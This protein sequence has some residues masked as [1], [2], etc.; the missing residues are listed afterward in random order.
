MK[1]FAARQDA[2][3]LTAPR[4]GALLFAGAIALFAIAIAPLI[5][6]DQPRAG[7]VDF[8]HLWSAG[9]MWASLR[10][11]YEDGRAAIFLQY[12]LPY[13]FDAPAP[14]FYPPHS[15]V[16]FGPLGFLSPG[17]AS[18]AFSLLSVAALLTSSVLFAD[19]MRMS[20]V[21]GSRLSLASAHAILL[22][23]GWNAGPVIFFHNIST[24]IIYLAIILV[25]RGVQIQSKGFVAAGLFFALI[26]PQMS[27]GIVISTL[28]LR[29]TRHA[30]A[31]AL[32]AVAIFS[33][34]GLAPGGVISSFGKFLSN[35]SAYS[36]YAANSPL[37][38]SGAAFLVAVATGVSLG[39]GIMVA[40]C[41]GVLFYLSLYSG[42]NG[43]SD[44]E[45]SIE[46]LLLSIV[47]GLFLLPSL[48]HYYIAV[49]PAIA[50]QLSRRSAAGPLVLLSA[51]M[52]MRSLDI[53]DVLEF[54]SGY[55]GSSGTAATDSIAILLLFSTSVWA[56]VEGRTPPR[57]IF[58]GVNLRRPLEGT[59]G[60]ASIKPKSARSMD[61]AHG[62]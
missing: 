24:L 28:I 61:D 43:E 15:I 42:R 12:G 54:L 44:I 53:R 9:K 19:M 10:C 37:H 11:P 18:L 1:Q 47:T 7:P 36:S 55:H 38:Q 56:W 32:A 57:Y 33:L 2:L 50:F 14:F 52:L 8:Y 39:A 60:K 41:A 62:R 13:L 45:R 4:I 58:Q 30:A 51:L 31:M 48:N 29:Q 34:S 16:I 6:L 3:D 46:F 27:V 49:I 22:M 26:S 17:A 35:I 21:F 20:G 59:G 23:A 40:A 25:V 5:I